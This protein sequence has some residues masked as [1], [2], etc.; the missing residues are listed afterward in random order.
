MVLVLVLVK[1]FRF[2]PNLRFGKLTVTPY[3]GIQTGRVWGSVRIDLIRPFNLF[4]FET[5]A[6]GA[7]ARGTWHVARGTHT[8]RTNTLTRLT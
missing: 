1:W 7:C 3:I 5:W 4:L 2:G 6:F 8:F